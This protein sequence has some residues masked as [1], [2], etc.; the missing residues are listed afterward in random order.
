[1]RSGKVA[2]FD[3]TD[4]SQRHLL[5]GIV[6]CYIAVFCVITFLLPVPEIFKLNILYSLVF[7]VLFAGITFYWKISY[8]MG[9]VGW[10]VAVL[11]QVF[12]FNAVTLSIAFIIT[13]LTAWSRIVLKKHTFWQTFVGF[14]LSVGLYY[15]LNAMF[16]NI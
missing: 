14:W 7:S 4:R 1:M 13:V 3:V 16:F 5:N 11:T 15:V 2:D 10:F 8:H 12:S 9:G 6:L